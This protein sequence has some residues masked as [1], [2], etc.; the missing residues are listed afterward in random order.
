MKSVTSKDV[1]NFVKEHVIHRFGIP[2][3][4]TTDGGSIFISRVDHDR[5]QMP[6]VVIIGKVI[7]LMVIGF[8]KFLEAA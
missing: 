7:Q 3:T 2:Q 5:I 6:S 1:I 4:I 8:S